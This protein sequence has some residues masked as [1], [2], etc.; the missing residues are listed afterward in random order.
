MTPNVILITGHPA[1]GKTTLS[2]KLAD[3]LNL[4]LIGK[5][6]IKETLADTMPKPAE[7]MDDTDWSRRLSIA[8]WRLLYQ[9]T[10][11]LIRA[12]VPHIV[13]ANFDPKFSDSHWQ[14]LMSRYT[15]NPIQIRCESDPQTIIRRYHQRI[16]DGSRHMIHVNTI[17][18]AHYAESIK[19]HMGWI[20]IEGPRYSFDSSKNIEQN[21]KVIFEIV[22]GILGNGKH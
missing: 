15:F 13:E 8:T 20:N 5:D 21:E 7:D 4:P 1:T 10:E 3:K 18:D 9:Q 22:Q 14:D 19:T 16:A 6:I 11:D 2:Y 12:K 17:P